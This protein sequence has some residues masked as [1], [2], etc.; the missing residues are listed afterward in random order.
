M[1]LY[2]YKMN[3][4][5]FTKIFLF[6]QVLAMCTGLMNMFSITSTTPKLK[7]IN[8]QPLNSNTNCECKEQMIYRQYLI[9][10]RKSRRL[11]NNATNINS[12][13]SIVNFTNQ[14]VSNYATISNTTSFDNTDVGA[15]NIIMGNMVLDVSNVK[16]IKISTEKD[17]IIVELDKQPQ[18]T[19]TNILEKINN[20][21]TII[22]TISL[23]G[24]IVSMN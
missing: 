1:N 18:K 16:Y 23:L 9:G 6:A 24:K 17:T 5:I 21:E 13:V 11:L 3:K 12:I 22:N 2:S 14:F 7:N 8:C 20:V 10:L 4:T 15:K 19:D